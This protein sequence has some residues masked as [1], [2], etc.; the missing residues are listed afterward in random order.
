MAIIVDAMGGDRAPGEIVAGAVSA[1]R[2]AGTRII[3]VGRESTVR[4]E[5]DRHHAAGLPIEIEHA[6]QVVEMEEHAAAAFRSKKNS[7]I[8]V[9]LR[10]V[11]EGRGS[12]FVSAGNSGAV[13]AAA[14]F[15]LGRIQGIDRPALGT[16]FPTLGRPTFM[17]D[18]GANVEVRPQ[19]LV[20]FGQMGAIYMQRVFGVAQPRVGL[21]SNGE[22][23]TKGTPVIQ[24]A[25]RLLAESDLN[26]VGNVEGKD[27]TRGVADVVV[28]D[29]FAGNIALKTAEGVGD[30]I[31][32]LIRNSLM[33]RIHFRVAAAVL[34][35]AFRS[36]AKTLDYT[37]YGGAPLLGVDGVTIV[38]HGRSDAKAISNAI[39]VARQ[40]VDQQLIEAIRSGMGAIAERQS[41]SAGQADTHD[42]AG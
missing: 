31:L 8:A 40:A 4:A 39:R 9:G 7:S 36:I 22:E 26:F 19:Y 15:V 35:P 28:C 34:R 30:L 32:T 17:I 21:L 25:H 27:V 42:R 6:E 29:G 20:Q 10:L 41:R 11:K 33:S 12:A 5:L 24:E 13:F 23:P 16:V 37:E 14:L 18:V 1:A 2:E 3:L 38:A